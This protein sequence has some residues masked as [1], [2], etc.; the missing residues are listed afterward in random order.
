MLLLH[1]CNVILTSS[2]SNDAWFGVPILVGDFTGDR[3][4]GD[5]NDDVMDDGCIP[6]TSSTTPDADARDLNIVAYSVT[7]IS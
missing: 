3:D 7:Q 2:S 4:G 6:L 5:D 1:I